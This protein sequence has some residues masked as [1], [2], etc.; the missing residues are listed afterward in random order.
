V[1]ARTYSG[2]GRIRVVPGA[3]APMT[4]RR[5]SRCLLATAQSPVENRLRVGLG[6]RGF[7]RAAHRAAGIAGAL[8]SVL[9]SK[10]LADEVR[11]HTSSWQA[12]SWNGTRQLEELAGELR[13]DRDALRDTS[14]SSRMASCSSVH[15]SC[16]DREQRPSRMKGRVG[17]RSPGVGWS[18]CFLEALRVADE[19]AMRGEA[20][21]PVLAT[22]HHQRNPGTEPFPCEAPVRRAV[23]IPPGWAAVLLYVRDVTEDRDREVRRLQSREASLDR[24][25]GPGVAHEINNPARFVLATWSAGLNSCSIGR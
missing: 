4:R 16:A 8:G 10:A 14:T 12:R 9:H 5:P 18:A 17:H 7:H 19:S 25:A 1:L 20:G 24:H 11:R 2:H 3:F 13:A 6:R 23:P 22:L 15:Q 21:R